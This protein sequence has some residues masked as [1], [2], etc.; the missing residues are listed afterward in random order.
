MRTLLIIISILLPLFFYSQNK[1]IDTIYIYFDR[2][3]DKHFEKKNGI[4]YFD[5]CLDNKRYVPFQYGTS[6]I[7]VKKSVNKNIITRKELSK[8]INNDNANNNLIFI[9]VKKLKNKTY[10]LYQ[11]DH[12]FRTITD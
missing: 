1:K 9:I 12:K 4:N 5:I 10:K 2:I 8:I 6:M 7:S 3:K 11:V